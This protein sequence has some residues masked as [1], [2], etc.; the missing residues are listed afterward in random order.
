MSTSD[1]PDDLAARTPLETTHV[2]ALTDSA[3][4]SR[5][6]EEPSAA[7]V[8]HAKRQVR[9]RFLR[10]GLVVIRLGPVLVLVFIGAI[11]AFVEPIFLDPQNLLDVGV[12]ASP[13]AVLA[14]GQLLV[15]LTRGIDLSVGSLIALSLVVGSLAYGQGETGGLLVIVVMVCTGA[16]VGLVNALV[17]VKGRIPHPFIVT[18]GMLNVASGL[19]LVLSGGRPRPGMPEIILTLG[20]GEL[21]TPVGSIPWPILLVAGTATAVLVLT[22]QLRWGRWIYALGANPEGARRMGLP[23]N[24][25]IVSVY[26]LSGVSAGIAAVIIA[27]RTSTAFPTAG[28]LAELDAIAAVIIGG[29][30]FFGGR[31][32]VA[33]AIV[34]ALII[35]VIRNGLNLSG[36]SPDWQPVVIGTVLVAAVGLDVL[37]GRLEARFRVYQARGAT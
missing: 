7:G 31:G 1:R 14:L 16:T 29:A 36:V 3:E 30:S 32:T 5:A 18:L 26:V 27:G 37:R 21:S 10:S 35:A 33:S 8:S 34:G 6:A 22:T 24:R 15:I 13:I 2:A 28:R 19:A 20:S 9:A 11:F 17:L 12:Q 25:I 23:V 4:E